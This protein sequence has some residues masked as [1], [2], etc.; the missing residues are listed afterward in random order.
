MPHIL[1]ETCEKRPLRRSAHM[2][3]L[4]KK[5]SKSWKKSLSQPH[6]A[7]SPYVD[8]RFSPRLEK[9]YLG[10]PVSGIEFTSPRQDK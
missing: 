3:S 7:L 1:M 8:A 9:G 4:G 2:F 5:R 6:L 10:N